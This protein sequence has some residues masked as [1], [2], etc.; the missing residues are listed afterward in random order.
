MAI[1]S[2][3]AISFADVNTEL[4][5]S[6]TATFSFDQMRGLGD[7]AK[8]VSISYSNMYN[9]AAETWTADVDIPVGRLASGCALLNDGRILVVGGRNGATVYA[10]AHILDLN[11]TW[12]A[13]TSCNTATWAHKMVT[14]NDGRVLKMGG[15]T[16]ATYGSNQTAVVEIYDPVTNAWTNGTSLPRAIADQAAVKLSDGRVFY[17]GGSRSD[18]SYNQETYIYDPIADTYTAKATMPNWMYFSGMG[19]ARLTDGNVICCGGENG[20]G[21]GSNCG[22]SSAIYDVANNSWTTNPSAISI[23][24]TSGGGCRYSSGTLPDGR[25][26]LYGGITASGVANNNFLIW[27][28]STNTWTTWQPGNLPL[29]AYTA[30]VTTLDG[31]VF[32]TSGHENTTYHTGSYW[33]TPKYR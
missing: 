19:I 23:L 22:P 17:C 11:G 10:Q 7:R 13:V 3:G 16:V 32:I 9:K 29:R 26:W 20:G 15:Y 27:K 12:T 4:N 33:Y 28:Q 30:G 6:A 2:S 21:G 8:G 24:P 5:R 31:R 25:I 18:I 14:L 1:K